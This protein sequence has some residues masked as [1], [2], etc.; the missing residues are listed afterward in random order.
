MESNLF[1]TLMNDY[2][3]I[4]LRVAQRLL[5]DM[6]AAADAVQEGLIKAYHARQQFAGNH[7]CA[8]FLR[9][10]TNTCYDKLAYEKR[11][12]TVSLDALAEQQGEP[13]PRR[14]HVHQPSLEQMICRQET[15]ES[16]LAAVAG[17]PPAHRA[18]LQRI[19]IEGYSYAEVAA[20]LQLPLGTVKSRLFRARAQLRDAL[21]AAGLVAA[22][23]APVNPLP[24]GSP[25]PNDSS[26]TIQQKGDLCA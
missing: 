11:R 2:T 7:L 15:W 8:W 13:L 12:K 14:G 6:D 22:A 21:V 1:P 24:N 5:G 4:A 19:D 25:T 23:P 3:P 26:L 16:V 10:V 9:I 18:V 20:E 17:L